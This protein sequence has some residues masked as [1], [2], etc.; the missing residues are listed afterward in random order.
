MYFYVFC[1]DLFV[2]FWILNKILRFLVSK[3]CFF[4]FS[5]QSHAEPSWNWLKNLVLDPKRAKVDQKSEHEHV[6]HVPK[7]P[8]E[9]G[10]PFRKTASFFVSTCFSTKLFFHKFNKG[11][12][13]FWLKKLRNTQYSANIYGIYK[14]TEHI[15]TSILKDTTDFLRS[16]NFL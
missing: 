10:I 9:G 13:C 8:S 11:L 6:Q 1:F 16:M 15:C 14:A 12:A 2:I 7:A 4:S 3:P 5:T